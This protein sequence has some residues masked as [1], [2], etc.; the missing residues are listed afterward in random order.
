MYSIY[1]KSFLNQLVYQPNNSITQNRDNMQHFLD[2]TKFIATNAKLAI[3]EFKKGNIQV[4]DPLVRDRCCQVHA[5]QILDIFKDQSVQEELPQLEGQIEK[6]LKVINQQ[7]SKIKSNKP[8]DYKEMKNFSALVE[9]LSLSI[10]ISRKVELLFNAYLLTLGTTKHQPRY[11]DYATLRDKLSKSLGL[12]TIKNIVSQARTILSESSVL[13]IQ[14]IAEELTSITPEEKNLLSERLKIVKS[15]EIKDKEG[16]QESNLITAL[17]ATCM[18]YNIQTVL[19]KA[20]EDQTLMMVKEF[21]TDKI[22]PKGIFFRSE[23]PGGPFTPVSKENLVNN[24]QVFVLKCEFAEDATIQQLTDYIQ[25][26]G[27]SEIV[28]ASVTNI[29]QF[30]SDNDLSLL[31]EAAQ[32][33]ISGYTEKAKSHPDQVLK[34]ILHIY[35]GTIKQEEVV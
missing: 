28:L 24:E 7:T 34:N 15:F 5:M 20:G 19:L 31:D 8:F 33:E 1:P 16:N 11:I 14:K 30:A 27:L 29:N 6:V 21:R 3:K 23:F 26:E 25:Q 10:E 12:D 35:P 18:F 9:E 32:E 2:L 13:Y 22:K 17:A 4:F